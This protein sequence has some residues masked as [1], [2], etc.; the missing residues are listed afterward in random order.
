MEEPRIKVV[1]VD[2]HPVVREGLVTILR[3]AGDVQ[4]VGVASTGEQGVELV[5][6]MQPDVT[7]MD[8]RLPAMSGLQAIKT[9]RSELRDARIIVLTTF[10]GDEDIYRAVEAGAV[11]YLLKD[12]A[13]DDLVRTVREVHQGGRPIP[14]EIAER[15]LQRMG[16][17]SLTRRELNVLSAMAM[18]L[19][20]KEI[21]FE[22][23]IS[24]ETVQVHVKSILSKLKVH[25]RTEAV[26][27][28]IK[29]GLLHLN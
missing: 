27:T 29:H 21:A 3:S 17:P 28:A 22:L 1:C 2:D 10:E 16:S 23:C 15:L 25:D 18:G 5:Y 9:I 4:V 24:K 19:R 7:V 13:A 11:T 26:T 20:N 8:L 6:Q 12:T 14:G